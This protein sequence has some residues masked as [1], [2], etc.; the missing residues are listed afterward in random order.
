[1]KVEAYEGIHGGLEVQAEVLGGW[2]SVDK[3]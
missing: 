1:M 3:V 2:G